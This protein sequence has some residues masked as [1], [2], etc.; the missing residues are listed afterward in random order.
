MASILSSPKITAPVVLGGRRPV[1]VLPPQFVR[2]STPNNKRHLAH[3]LAHLIARDPAWQTMATLVCSLLWWHPLAWWSRRQLHAAHEAL[4][5]EASLAVP[6][7]PRTLAEALV[8]FG[9]RLVRPELQFG[10]SLGGGRFRS[11]LGRRVQRLLELPHRRRSPIR[12]ARLAFVHFSLPVLWR[13]RPYRN[14]LGSL[15]SFLE[16]GETTMSVLT[17]SWRCSLVAT[18][19]WT[20][21]ACATAR[22]RPT[23][24]RQAHAP[25]G[26]RPPEARAAN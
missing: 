23:T 26:G 17:S 10:L 19:M 8:L 2:D 3:E 15:P 13:W 18:A 4:A 24:N 5:D 21:L 9:Q 20:M 12:R 14:R 1:L 7:G 11:A 22:R 25:G 16:A 6:D